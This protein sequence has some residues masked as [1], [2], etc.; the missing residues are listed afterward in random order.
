[1]KPVS[2]P[3]THEAVQRLLP[4]LPGGTLDE[5]ETALVQAHLHSCALCRADLDWQHKLGAAEPA[6]DPAFDPD[7]ALAR[8]LPRLEPQSP[9]GGLRDWWRTSS[10]ASG[11]WLRWTVAAQFAVIGVL[12][13][14][15][16]QPGG[17]RAGYRALGAAAR[18]DG[19]L[20]VMFTPDTSEAE[21]RRIVR[22]SGAR[23]VDGPTVTDAWVLS[24]PA[25]GSKDALARLRAERSVRLAQPLLAESRP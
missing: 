9:R 10:A 24:V 22:A 13:A 21:L 1:M 17:E 11:T 2:A 14:M 7:R 12:A 20:V 19:N 23:V 18:T 15:L 16:V 6:P 5:A 3:D 4:W 25:A 8:L